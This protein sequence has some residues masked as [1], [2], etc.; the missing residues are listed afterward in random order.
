MFKTAIALLL[1]AAGTAEA[2]QLNAHSLPA[3]QSLAETQ[4][5]NDAERKFKKNKKNHKKSSKKIK[6]A[7]KEDKTFDKFSEDADIRAFLAKEIISRIKHYD[8]NKDGRLNY[9]EAHLLALDE[10]AFAQEAIEE[11]T[12]FQS[13]IN[14]GLPSM[15]PTKTESYSLEQVANQALE[16][17]YGTSDDYSFAETE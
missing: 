10:N 2:I 7:L 14:N 15:Y 4:L 13:M 9:T 1:A 5:S 6:D 11:L 16:E 12:H 8:V 17:I 3:H